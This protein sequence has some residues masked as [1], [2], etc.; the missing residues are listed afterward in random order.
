MSHR[1]LFVDGHSE[2]LERIHRQLG[3]LKNDWELRF[4]GSAAEA[5]NLLGMHPCD[6]LVADIGLQE[7]D[8]AALLAEVCRRWP[9]IIR[10]LMADASQQ[11]AVVRAVGVYHR[12]VVKPTEPGAL[13][14]ALRQALVLKGLVQNENVRKVVTGLR[15]MPTLPTVYTRLVE[16]LQSPDCSL[17]GVGKIVAADPGLTSRVLQ[18]VNS[19]CFGL[20]RRITSPSVAAGLLG[21][22]MLRALVLAGGI[23][24]QFSARTMREL[25]PERV[26]QRSA[27]V[28]ALARSVVLS[29]QGSREESEDA[30]LAGIMQDVGQLVMA[31]SHPDAYREV[32][33]A[34]GQGESLISLE[35]EAFSTE[36]PAVGAYLLGLWNLP[37]PAVEAVA[38]HH[39]RPAD[40]AALLGVSG[41]VQVANLLVAEHEGDLAARAGVAVLQQGPLS[42]HVGTWQSIALTGGAA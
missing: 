23:F 3:A 4:A 32:L 14:E 40:N 20:S 16:E 39:S 22:N 9:G 10:M 33:A 31:H 12:V 35:R 42:A 41:A 11:A 36:H 8:G 2:S 27:Q 24:G 21:L 13:A 28:G 26:W 37:G 17:D 18:L 15:A 30:F 34:L 5:L 25:A 29:L 38:F 19:A 7:T 6:V 1:A